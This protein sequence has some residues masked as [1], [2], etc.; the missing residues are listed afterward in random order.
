LRLL[1]HVAQSRDPLLIR[2]GAGELWRLPGA[3]DFASQLARCPLRYVMSDELVRLCVELGF[4]EGDELS[5]CLDLLHFPAEEL[6]I[7]WDERTRRSALAQLLP[8]CV[9][10]ADADAVRGGALLRAD[11]RGRSASLRT[12]WLTH[13]ERPEP[14]LAAVE[15]LID[16]DGPAGAPP[17]ASLLDGEAVAVHDPLNAQLDRLLQCARFR[18]D[19][20]WQ[21]YYRAVAHGAVARAAVLRGSLAT[22]AFD[23]PLLLSLFLLMTLRLGLPQTPVRPLRLNLKRARL[24]K[25]ALLEHI[26]VCCPVFASAP[27][28]RGATSAVARGAPRFHH[29]RGHIV[30][31]DDSI[32]WRRAHWRGHLRLGAVRSRTV[33]LRVPGGHPAFSSDG[34]RS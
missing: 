23:V 8:E 21:R 11:A 13:G 5:G 3:G 33:E 2:Q 26:E 6:W 24:G 31:R 10:T 1:D 17:H 29:V 19:A 34:W 27:L 15:T 32:F 18:L 12:F 20:A 28:W 16:L 4:S 9:Q 22:V 14:L 30:R 25:P 7:E